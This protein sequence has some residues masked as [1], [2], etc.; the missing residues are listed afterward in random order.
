ML[1]RITWAKDKSRELG[2]YARILLE[3]GTLSENPQPL[4]NEISGIESLAKKELTHEEEN[5]LFSTM[6][7]ATEDLSPKQLYYLL[8]KLRTESAAK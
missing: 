6:V 7:R 1:H 3:V 4:L 8:E 5:S 2:V